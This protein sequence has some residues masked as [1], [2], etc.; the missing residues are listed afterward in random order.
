MNE[1]EIKELLKVYS[2]DELK[3]VIENRLRQDEI[4]EETTSME[5]KMGDLEELAKD[6]FYG[7]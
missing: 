6:N 2:F 4:Q 1:E 7:R 5:E 3:A